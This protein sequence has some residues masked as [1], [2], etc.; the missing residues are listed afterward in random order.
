M[1]KYYFLVMALAALMSC[2][3]DEFVGDSGSP[4]GV[5][6]SGAESAIS[7]N[8]NVPTVTRAGEV[9]G[10]TAATALS[11]QFIIWGE[12]N[13][14]S[15]SEASAGNLVFKNYIV[16]WTDNSAYTTTSNTKNWEYVGYKFDDDTTVDPVTTAYSTNI[17][18]NTKVGSDIIP[19]TIKYWDYSASSYTFTAVS[20]LPADITAGKVVIT[21][22]TSG[23]TVYDKGYDIAVKADAIMD[24][25]FVADRN[26]PTTGTGTDR[27]ATNTYGGNVTMKFRNFMSKIRF[28]L[29]ETIPGYKVNITNVYYNSTNST[30]SSKFGVDGKFLTA[31]ANTAFT[32]TYGNGST[33]GPVNKA[34]VDVKSG[35]TPDGQDYLE[36]AQSVA[37]SPI[38][39]TT[40]ASPVSAVITSPTYDKTAG[41]Y[42]T[43]LPYT[44]N[45]TNMKVK[46]DFT[47]TSEDT[48]ETITVSDATAE[49]PAA[50]CQ[51]KSNYAYTYILKLNDNTNGQISG[52]T[53]LYPITFDAVQVTDENG[54]AEYITTVSEPSITTLGVKGSAYSVGQNE[55]AA[56]TDVYTTVVDGGSVV[57]LTKSSNI[58]LYTVI[59][60]G[61]TEAAVAER[62]IEAPAMNAAQITA[63]NAK[64]NPTDVTTAS[65]TIQ[66]TVPMEDNVS[67]NKTVGTDMV[68]K[69][70]T[71]ASTKYAIVYQKVAP[72]YYVSTG[73]KY[74]DATAFATA[75]S[76]AVDS[77]LYTDEDCRSEATTWANASTTYYQINGKTYTSEQFVAA[78]QLYTDAACTTKAESWTDGSTTYYKPTRVKSKG[79]V[80]VKV[81]N[82][83]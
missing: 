41:A 80:V 19:Q 3:S 63:A 72:T 55:Y 29:Y 16:R 20:A 37:G 26:Q 27:N 82:C 78:G 24:K 76:A 57:A 5:N 33:T 71:E 23:S 31:G 49:I 7:F 15:G 34:I 17:T 50:Y 65:L 73:A 1:K 40:P 32:V 75:K 70:T 28:G 54:D 43:I 22:N 4:N 64:T 25:I 9:G 2:S 79:T 18:P 8:L 56:S 38:L 52:V 10:N 69:F 39:S 30:A 51:W 13:E 36:T 67:N 11:N 6:G 61:I 47:L 46:F 53:G 58:W 12:K 45:T 62:L 77:K 42:T 66:N 74:A 44:S 48:G 35:T 60:T 68:A 81:V 21:K 83:P 14:S 59:G